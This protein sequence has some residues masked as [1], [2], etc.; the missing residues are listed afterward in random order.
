MVLDAEGQMPENWGEVELHW[1]I[2]RMAQ[3][4]LPPPDQHPE[5]WIRFCEFMEKK[6][7]KIE[8]R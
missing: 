5:E 2:A 4:A 6:Y 3:H 1:F 7:G 8:S